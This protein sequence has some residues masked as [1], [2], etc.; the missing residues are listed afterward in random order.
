MDTSS[1]EY[2][3]HWDCKYGDGQGHP[4]NNRQC[5]VSDGSRR[6]PDGSIFARD[7]IKA[8]GIAIRRHRIGRDGLVQSDNYV[9]KI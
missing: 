8:G 6:V 7:H 1:Q 9:T 4:G 2:P 5:T 3:H